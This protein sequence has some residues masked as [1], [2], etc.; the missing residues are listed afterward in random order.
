MEIIGTLSDKIINILNL[1][2]ITDKNIY[3]GETNIEHMKTS[4]PD[5]YSKYKDKIPEILKNP[6]YIGKNSKDDSIE[7]VKEFIINHE[8]V[9]V[10]VRV[11]SK[12]RLY[13]CSVYVLNRRRVKNFIEKGTLKKYKYI[14]DKNKKLLYK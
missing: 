6:D 14:I 2:Y 11:S 10:A 4:H 8:Y 1:S 3:I 7:F 12:N 13:A 5:D 9:K